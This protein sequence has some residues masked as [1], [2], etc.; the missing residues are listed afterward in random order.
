MLHRWQ[1]IAIF[2]PTAPESCGTQTW[3]REKRKKHICNISINPFRHLKFKTDV[4]STQQT[5][6]KTS[7]PV[8][9]RGLKATPQPVELVLQ[10]EVKECL[11]PWALGSYLV[12]DSLVDSIQNKL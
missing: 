4:M 12:Q 3:V 11:E 7:L 5:L 6:T 8:A 2:H 9:N 10:S 1:P